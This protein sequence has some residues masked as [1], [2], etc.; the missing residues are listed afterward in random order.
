M[1]YYLISGFFSALSAR[2]IL[3]AVAVN[4]NSKP[5]IVL[6]GPVVEEIAKTGSAMLFNAGIFYTH[7]VF[8]SLELV[9]DTLRRRGVWPGL[10]ALVLHSILG[11]ATQW[12]LGLYGS[13]ALALTVAV[14]LHAM[15]NYTS[16]V[17]LGPNLK[18]SK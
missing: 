14:L 18:K 13:L 15:W 3:G 8:G 12:L 1:I 6:L 2:V 17:L 9:M 7:V 5:V 16:V 11:F 4:S 10:A